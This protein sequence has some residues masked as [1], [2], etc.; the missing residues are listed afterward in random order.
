MS[1]LTWWATNSGNPRLAMILATLSLVF[2]VLI[3]IFVIPPLARSAS[4]EAAQIDLPI[5]ITSGGLIFLGLMGIVGFA[6][7]NTGNNLLFLV[8]AFLFATLLVSFWVGFW[9]LRKL[10]VKIRFPESVFAENPTPFTVSLKNGKR[11]FPSV[12]VLIDLRGRERERLEIAEILEIPLSKKWQDRIFRAPIIKRTLD[13][14]VYLPH[15]GSQENRN[16]QVFDKRGR[17]IIKDF[18]LS[19]KFPFGFFRQRRRLETDAAE[20][21]IFPKIEQVNEDFRLWT[22]NAGK[23]AS[24]KRGQGQDLLAMR[25]YQPQD[26]LRNIDWKA[27]ARTRRMMVREYA[28]EDERRVT[29]VLDTRVLKAELPNKLTL[30][31]LQKNKNNGLAQIRERF[32]RAV[33]ETASLINFFV[34]Q[35]VEARLIIDGEIGDFSYTNEHL[36]D[37]LRRLALVEPKYVHEFDEFTDYYEE[38]EKSVEENLIVVVSLTKHSALFNKL[39]EKAKFINF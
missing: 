25:D 18:E 4:A 17:F 16:E 23:F 15:S 30:R 38:L 10:Q 37:C 31:E 29:I 19:T 36:T 34:K 8:F 12:S 6:A 3:L 32:E 28:A 7:W 24:T 35:R 33:S 27:T 14:F 13:Y 2:V 5:D 21:L 20:I 26:N 11:I 9:N 39:D 1:L 22:L